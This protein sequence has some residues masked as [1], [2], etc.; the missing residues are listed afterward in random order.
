MSLLFPFGRRLLPRSRHVSKPDAW[1]FPRLHRDE[2]YAGF[3]K[4]RLN[5]PE[6][7]RRASDIWGSFD[8]LYGR[9]TNRCQHSELPLAEA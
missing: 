1:P 3:L 4:G 5:L 7:I 6:R 8:P 2:F 9:K